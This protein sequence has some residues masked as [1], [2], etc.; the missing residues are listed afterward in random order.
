VDAGA[1]LGH[2]ISHEGV[3]HAAESFT[4]RELGERIGI[5]EEDGVVT[6]TKEWDAGADLLKREDAGVEAVIEVGREISDFVCQIDELCFEWRP[7]VEEVF[8]KF[9]VGRGVVIAR[10]LD[11]AFADRERQVESA[12]GSIALFKPGD[13]AKSVE[14]VIEAQSVRLEGAVEGLFA[15]VAEGRMADVMDQSQ[16]FGKNGVEAEG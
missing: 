5:L 11:D 12:K 13:D 14:V 8:R 10:V 16:G 6:T 9:G 4:D 3:E 1:D 7:E 15:S 2:E